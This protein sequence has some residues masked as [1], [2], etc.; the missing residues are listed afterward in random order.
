MKMSMKI[1]ITTITITAAFALPGTGAR[2]RSPG[3]TATTARKA[4]WLAWRS[5]MA[6]RPGSSAAGAAIAS[7]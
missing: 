6:T 5:M 4:G 2:P 3:W 1:L 7:A